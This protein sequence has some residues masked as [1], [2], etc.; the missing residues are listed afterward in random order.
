VRPPSSALVR[1]LV[2]FRP[3]AVV[4]AVLASACAMAEAVEAASIAPEQV[5]GP[6]DTIEKK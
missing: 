6:G 3:L 2:Q 1:V 4:K 5:A